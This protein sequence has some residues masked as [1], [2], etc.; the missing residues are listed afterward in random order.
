VIVGVIAVQVMQ[1]PVVDEIDMGAVLDTDVFLASVA[2]GMIVARHAGAEF[3]GLGIGGADVE[4]VFVDMPV[5]AVV[6]VAVVEVID[7]ARMF[8]RLMAAGL[9]VAV[10][11]VASVKHLVRHGGRGETGECER[12]EKQGPVHDN[13]LQLRRSRCAHTLSRPPSHPKKP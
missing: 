7:M 12:S 2:V 10:G 13:A 1:P 3:L 4:R 6:Q 9:A 8:E 11:I 5:M